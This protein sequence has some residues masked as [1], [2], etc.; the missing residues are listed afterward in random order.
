MP[1][2]YLLLLL[3]LSVLNSGCVLLHSGFENFG[4]R[5]VKAVRDF[6]EKKRNRH[7]AKVRW[8]EISQTGRSCCPSK[9][10]ENGFL[11][12][13]SDQLD[14]G[15]LRPPVLPPKHYRAVKYQTPEGSNAIND[16]FAGY[17]LGIAEAQSTQLRY[18][19]TGPSSVRPYASGPVLQESGATLLP[20][21]IEYQEHTREP[22][23][24][25]PLPPKA[26][27]LPPVPLPHP[28]RVR[29]TPPTPLMLNV[30][31]A[32]PPSAIETPRTSDANGMNS[33]DEAQL[34]V[35]TVS[36]EKLRSVVPFESPKNNPTAFPSV[37]GNPISLHIQ[38]KSGEA[39][40]EHPTLG[41]P[42]ERKRSDAEPKEFR[43]K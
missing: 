1:R 32:L 23:T 17:R 5:S 2:R 6:H 19:V 21:M 4:Y 16:W 27:E 3:T 30:I 7:W 34:G 8:E 12:G 11:A 24:S 25:A 42:G 40:G 15:T 18:L 22:T 43:L 41:V 9:H 36:H 35:P 31:P 38:A 14:D 10:Y 29:G 26:Q 28:R 39:S 37:L 20:P 13:F 33:F